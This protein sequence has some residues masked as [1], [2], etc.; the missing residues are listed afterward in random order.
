MDL[1]PVPDK[2][3]PPADVRGILND[4]DK[5]AGWLGRGAEPAR[6]R[7]AVKW[8]TAEFESGCDMRDA[9]DALD[10][11]IVEAGPSRIGTLL[12]RAVRSVRFAT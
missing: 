6:V 7:E 9:I 1:M 2:P 3:D 12:R 8:L 11:R 4:L 10:S 5:Y